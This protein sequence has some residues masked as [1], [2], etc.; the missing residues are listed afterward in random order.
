MP[1]FEPG[2]WVNPDSS[3]DWWSDGSIGRFA[4]PTEGGRFERHHHDAHEVWLVSEGRA[5]ILL[6]GG[7][8]YVQGGDI[9]VTQAGDVHDV[10]EV[11]ETLRGFFIELPPPGG[12][13]PGHL[14]PVAHDVPALPVPHDFP[15]RP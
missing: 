10:V 4:V 3:P 7:E 11:Y 6:E 8:H 14:D 5:K 15:V 9:V 12:G 13:R 2:S 1:I